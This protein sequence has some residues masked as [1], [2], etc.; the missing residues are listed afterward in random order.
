ML[1]KPQVSSP[2]SHLVPSLF[3]DALPAIH[4]STYSIYHPEDNTGTYLAF[5]CH[6][7]KFTKV[8]SVEGFGRRKRYVLHGKREFVLS[9][10]G[11]PVR[12]ERTH[13][14]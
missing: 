11:P 10:N 5:S 4:A 8:S 14:G 1:G 7:R 12:R 2:L 6:R 13:M 3:A 9:K